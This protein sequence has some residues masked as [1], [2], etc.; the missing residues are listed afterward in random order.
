MIGL[1]SYLCVSVALCV[2]GLCCL[3]A[4][5][6][7]LHSLIGLELIL[8]AASINFVAFARFRDDPLDGRIFALFVIIL[9]AAEVAVVLAISLHVV[10][11]KRSW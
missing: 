11:V 4:R 9:A 2:I 10:R 8:N 7:V 6:D 5:R 1:G 3:I